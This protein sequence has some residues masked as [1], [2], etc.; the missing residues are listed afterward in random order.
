MG[1]PPVLLLAENNK[2]KTRGPRKSFRVEGRSRYCCRG[3][4]CPVLRIAVRVTF[5]R[6][7][8]QFVA[9]TIRL[10]NTILYNAKHLGVTVYERNGNVWKKTKSA[11]ARCVHGRRT[12]CGLVL[13]GGL[14]KRIDILSACNRRLARCCLLMW[15]GQFIFFTSS[16]CSNT[17][18]IRETQT[19][20]RDSIYEHFACS[21]DQKKQTREQRL[22]FAEYD[23]NDG[24]NIIKISNCNQTRRHVHLVYWVV[25]TYSEINTISV[26]RYRRA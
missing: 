26:N 17:C 2:R 11:R 20:R 24:E 15:N 14:G 9:Y 7:Y 22:E 18:T 10:N 21:Q 1:P 23:V 25:K 8:T 6:P 19:A 4:F 13:F 3:C 5:L 12:H 16:C